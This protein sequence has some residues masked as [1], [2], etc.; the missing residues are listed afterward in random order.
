MKNILIT[1]SGG[2]LGARLSKYLAE[3]GNNITAFIKRDVPKNNEWSN[4]MNDI[5]VGDIRDEKAVASLTKR[6]FDIVAHLISLD[7]HK[8]EDTPNYISSVNVMPTWNLLDTFTKRGLDKFIL[9]STFE[10]L[11]KVPLKEIDE[12]VKPKPVNNYG[13]THLLSENIVNYFNNKTGTNCI[14]IRITNGYGTPVFKENNCWWLVINDLCKLAHSKQK[15]QLTSDGSP[16]RDFIHISDICS[17]V[18]ILINSKIDFK[19]NMIYVASGETLNILEL[20]HIIKRVYIERYQREIDIYLPDKSVSNDPNTFMEMD[21]FY[22]NTK[23][24]RNLGFKPKTELRNG[25]NNIF[26]YLRSEII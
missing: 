1:G 17:A 11:G 22:V 12:S 20:A 21:K 9:F 24:L 23:K 5:I 6:N 8:C 26:T 25:I 14:N 4:L 18:E 13:L 15:I 2:Y 7:H 19:D 3:N 10:V 16:Q